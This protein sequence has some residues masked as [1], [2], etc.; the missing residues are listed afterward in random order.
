MAIIRSDIENGVLLR[1]NEV[2]ASDAG[3]LAS[4]T[5]ATA[6]LTTSQALG[7]WFDEC[8]TYMARHCLPW[9]GWGSATLAQNTERFTLAQLTAQLYGATGDGS[10]LW[11][12]RQCAVDGVPITRQDSQVARR[13]F[14]GYRYYPPSAPVRFWSPE[15]TEVAL[16]GPIT[17]VSGSLVRMDGYVIPPSISAVASGSSITW[18]PDYLTYALEYYAA[19]MLCLKNADDPILGPRALPLLQRFDKIC[20]Q[21]YEQVSPNLRA[22]IY[23]IPPIPVAPVGVAA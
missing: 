14:L 16:T 3:V 7:K 20:E 15:G 1:I 4:G 17:A 22:L 8:Q 2:G 5:G 12:G 10:V 6:T 11:M 21:Q 23:P 9:A 19:G 18:W 13:I